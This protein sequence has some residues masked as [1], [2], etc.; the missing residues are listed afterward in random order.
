MCICMYIYVY[1]YHLWHGEC[2]CLNYI[3][4]KRSAWHKHTLDKFDFIGIY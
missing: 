4:A 2:V 3:V 1:I